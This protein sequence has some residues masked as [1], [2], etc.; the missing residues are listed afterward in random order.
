LVLKQEDLATGH[1]PEWC[2]GC[3]NF[4]ILK[5]LET[6][7]ME[8]DIP[9]EK[10]VLATGIG[11]HGKLF[12]YVNLNGFHCIHGR[13]LPFATGVK[14]SNHSL[15]VLGFA[16]DGDAFDEGFDHFP[17]AARRNMDIKFFVH[18]N[19]VYGLTTGQTSPTSE[20]GYKSKT[21]PQGSVA[22]PINPV[23]MALSSDASFVARAFVGDLKHLASIMRAAI[24]HPGFA[25][26]DILQ[27]CYTFNK[28]NTYQ[29]YRDRV[30]K[31]DEDGHDP[32][33]LDQAVKRSREWG[34]RIPIGI[35]Y[36]KPRPVY[37]LSLHQLKES[38]L[39]EADLRADGLD[40]FL[41][42]FE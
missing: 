36:Q 24:K 39:V 6:T 40:G 19:R 42:L 26:V 5:A 33:N 9:H 7:I 14:L 3:G 34:S 35:F 32:Q 21:T 16:G 31:L 22:Y 28:V 12:N 41:G 17:H 37:H 23:L 18:N 2:P 27:V 8:L 30:Y 13:V 29:F 4:A 25:F 15:T 38:P 1:K 10:Y 11:C 20:I